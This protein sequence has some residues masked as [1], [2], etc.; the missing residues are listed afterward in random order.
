MPSFLSGVEYLSLPRDPQPWIIKDLIPVSGLTNIYGK[1]KAGK[2]MALDTVIPTPNGWTTMASLEPGDL[3]FG[4]DGL[5]TR[6]TAISDVQHA[7]TCYRVSFGDNTAMIVDA[8]HL[9]EVTKAGKICP[10]CNPPQVLTTQQLLDKQFVTNGGNGYDKAKWHI[11]LPQAL[12]Y[13]AQTNALPLDPY[14]LGAWLGDGTSCNSQFT[15]ADSEIVDHIKAAGWDVVKQPSNVYGYNVGKLITA[16]RVIGVANNKHIPETYLRASKEAR[17]ALL[18]GLMDTD[19]TVEN[20]TAIFANTNRRLAQ[21]TLELAR[22]LGLKTNWTEGKAY[23]NGRYISPEYAVRVR[24]H[25]PVFRLTRKA[26]L[27]R[28]NNEQY[29]SITNIEPVTSV[30][31]KCIVVEAKDHLFL[32]GENCLPTH[33]SFASL[34]M[35]LAIA[36]NTPEWLG[37]SVQTHGPVAYLQI[38]TPRGEWASR[39]NAFRE[40]GEDFSNI[41]FADMLMTPSYPFNILDS[42]QATWFKTALDVIKP[43]VVFIDTLR[44]AHGLDENDSTAMRNVVTQIV[45]AARPAAIV[46]ISHSRKDTMFTATGGD[47]L[48]NDARGSSYVAGRMDTVIKFTTDTKKTSGMLY[49]GRSVGHGHLALT[50]DDI[51]RVILDGEAALYHELVHVRSDAMRAENPKVSINAIVED[52]LTKTTYRKSR[53]IGIH[54]KDYLQSLGLQT[55]VAKKRR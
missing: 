36:N 2:A 29:W 42:D 39:L 18:Q 34:G 6:I 54:V 19:G 51:G 22:S 15:S 28:M 5:P 4:A 46:L 40:Q 38:D 16:L 12:E 41:Y 23:L 9:W 21:D 10:H 53:A 7:R 25:V 37:F 47:D 26:L 48:M 13:P 27:Q 11:R 52:I 33:N 3:V 55:G 14:V 17:L 1:P 50:Q 20:G 30:P 31:V 24:A 45:S 35:A 44:E 32:A 49:K 8:D 43:V